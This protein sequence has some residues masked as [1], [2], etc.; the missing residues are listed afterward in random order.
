MRDTCDT[1]A[2]AGPSGVRSALGRTGFEAG[3][4]LAERVGDFAD[5]VG[6]DDVAAGVG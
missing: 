5:V 2:G 6:G 4:G 3:F 1:N